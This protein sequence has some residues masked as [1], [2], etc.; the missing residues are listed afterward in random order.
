MTM[1]KCRDLDRLVSF[2]SGRWIEHDQLKI[3]VD[4]VGFRQG[5]TVVERLR[6]YG[7]AAFEVGA[8]LARWNQ[9]IDYLGWSAVHSPRQMEALIMELIQRNREWTERN[10]E[11]GITWF[12]TPGLVG[13]SAPTF[14]MHLNSI[15]SA[16]N[17]RRQTIG[18]PLVITNVRQP[19]PDV[20]SRG[21]KVR[22]R[23]H[24]Y[25]ADNLA[26]QKHSD[27]SGVLIDD[28]AT[29][30]E[31]SISNLAIVESGVIVSPPPDQVLGGI[32]QSVVRRIAEEN[33]IT[34]R[35][36]RITPH[37]LAS[38]DEVLLMGTDTGVWFANRVDDVM[39]NGGRSGPMFQKLAG[40]P[41]WTGSR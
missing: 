15:D 11:F 31:T 13:G 22:C 19:H 25:R 41:I 23:L 37:R 10:R 7:G 20:W 26:F 5:V 17:R 9:S 16:V 14:A 39:V 21:I 24:Y 38:A 3:S 34:W 28:D 1:S 4:D 18:Q 27:A 6:T 8:H 29:V 30:T 33:S 35:D 36:E 40:D 2:S 12:M 32:T